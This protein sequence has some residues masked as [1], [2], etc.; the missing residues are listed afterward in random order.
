MPEQKARG[1][2]R[3][4]FK[5]E[6]AVTII[7]MLGGLE[8]VADSLELSIDTLYRWGRPEDVGGL[9]GQI[10]LMYWD[11][12]IARSKRRRKVRTLVAADFLTTGPIAAS[13]ARR[14]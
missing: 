3:S 14:I 1:R 4:S 9:G 13:K 11:K 5:C 6:P 8:A 10:P 7:E 12:L 2:P